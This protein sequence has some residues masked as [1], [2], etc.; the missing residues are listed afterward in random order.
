M[1]FEQLLSSIDPAIY[2]NLKRAIELGKWPDGRTLTKEQRELCLQAVISYEHNNLPA[3]K[4][5]GY[6]PPKPHE[7]CGGKGDVADPDEEKPLNWQH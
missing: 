3:E 1:N 2:Q 6:I 7:H 5:T 4:H